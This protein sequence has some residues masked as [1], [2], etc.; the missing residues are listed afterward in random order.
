[1]KTVKQDESILRSRFADC[2]VCK[3]HTL[4]VKRTVQIGRCKSC[5]ETYKIVV[6]YV[7]TGKKIRTTTAGSET[8]AEKKV[9]PLPESG[10]P[11]W[12]I[13]SDSALFGTSSEPYSGLSEAL[14]GPRPDGKGGETSSTN[15]Q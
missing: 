7:K 12:Q 1:M 2:P 10:L 3:N 4:K 6:V 8:Q 11:A 5:N 14:F 15:S 13:P 9:E